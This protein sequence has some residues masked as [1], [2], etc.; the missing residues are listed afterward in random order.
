MYAS[1]SRIQ[2]VYPF[3]FFSLLRCETRLSNPVCHVHV[4][5]VNQL[6]PERRAVL[7]YSTFTSSQLTTSD[8]ILLQS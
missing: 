1:Y 4:N 7:Q 2:F 5:T 3:N 8:L 6:P